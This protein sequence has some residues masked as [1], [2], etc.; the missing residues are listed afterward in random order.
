[1]ELGDRP[2]HSGDVSIRLP[3]LPFGRRGQVRIL[4]FRLDL[5]ALGDLLQDMALDLREG[6]P[7]IIGLTDRALEGVQ[8]VIR[9][10]GVGRKGA[11]TEP[12]RQIQDLVDHPAAIKAIVEDYRLEWNLEMEWRAGVLP[13]IEGIRLRLIYD[14][15]L[16]KKS[17]YHMDA[18]LLLPDFLVI[19]CLVTRP[20]GRTV[21]LLAS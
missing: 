12:V 19:E 16:C 15:E 1:M 10:L 13:L 21:N 8:Q 6:V 4:D 7:E 2:V 3:S 20:N 17:R 14:I 18:S 5:I 11:L 9:D